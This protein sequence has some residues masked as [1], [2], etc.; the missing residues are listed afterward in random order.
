MLPSERYDSGV[1]LGWN[2]TGQ[3]VN[4]VLPIASSQRLPE[5]KTNEPTESV[6]LYLPK[7][8]SAVPT[9]HL[10]HHVGRGAERPDGSRHTVEGRGDL[11]LEGDMPVRPIPWQPL[12]CPRKPACPVSLAIQPG[13]VRTDK[14]RGSARYRA[15]E[16]NLL[17]VWVSGLVVRTPRV[18][19]SGL[20][21][22]MPR[23]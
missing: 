4:I 15:F 18:C 12:P 3:H 16:L 2:G 8:P 14:Q 10:Q 7:T 19:V 21:V 17:P 13:L 5:E 9:L 20:M 6:V 1:H 11:P 23:V 22:R